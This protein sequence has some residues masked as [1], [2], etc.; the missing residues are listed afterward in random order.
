MVNEQFTIITAI[1][2]STFTILASIIASLTNIY[3]AIGRLEGRV[4]A[5]E[6]RISSLEERMSRVERKMDVYTLFGSSLLGVRASWGLMYIKPHSPWLH[7]P[8]S[9]ISS[10]PISTGS[11]RSG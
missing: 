10:G 7:C 8:Q 5:L 4:I 3:R 11:T 1:V 2:A 9:P 6:K